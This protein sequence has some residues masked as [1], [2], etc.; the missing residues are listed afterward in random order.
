LGIQPH[1]KKTV[2]RTTAEG[3]AGILPLPKGKSFITA[4]MKK[5]QRLAYANPRNRC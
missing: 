3:D 4:K 1:F 2:R 5:N